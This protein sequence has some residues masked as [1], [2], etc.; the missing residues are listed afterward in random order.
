MLLLL[1]AATLFITPPRSVLA[2]NGLGTVFKSSEDYDSLSTPQQQCVTGLFAP[3]F[4]SPCSDKDCFCKDPQFISDHLEDCLQLQDRSTDGAFSA[5]NYNVIMG[6]YGNE[7]GFQ[8]IVKVGNLK[9][10]ANEIH[11]FEL[12]RSFCSPYL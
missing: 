7:C 12:I 9:A 3:P 6:F 11:G 2:P 5:G 8:P 1:L 4:D 10:K